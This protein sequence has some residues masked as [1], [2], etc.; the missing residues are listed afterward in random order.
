[1]WICEWEKT[2]R[3]V[4][5]GVQHMLLSNFPM[6]CW[7]HCKIHLWQ[8]IKKWRP[9]KK[10]HSTQ[11]PK[12]THSTIE[13]YTVLCRGE[14]FFCSEDGKTLKWNDILD[15]L[16]PCLLHTFFIHFSI[17]PHCFCQGWA[18]QESLEGVSIQDL[19]HRCR[20]SGESS[21]FKA[22]VWSDL[23]QMKPSE[24]YTS[25]EDSRKKWSAKCLLL[26][27]NN[28]IQTKG[29][30]AKY[31]HHQM[32]ADEFPNQYQKIKNLYHLAYPALP[33]CVKM[34]L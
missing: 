33:C 6:P 10:T 17:T 25:F 27:S 32:L 13:V 7:P 26:V 8:D 11:L 21:A 30:A 3:G 2:H 16:E 14:Y 12:F 5:R 18:S 4:H 15:L 1:M 9:N 29:L 28:L 24:I 23:V 19:K 20:W 34:A 22:Y 31:V